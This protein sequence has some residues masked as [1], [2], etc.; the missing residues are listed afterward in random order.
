MSRV[1]D[2]FE[3]FLDGAFLLFLAAWLTAPAEE[4]QRE[5]LRWPEPKDDAE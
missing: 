1:R 5:F 3:D 4:A 2:K